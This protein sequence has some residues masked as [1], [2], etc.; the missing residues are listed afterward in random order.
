MLVATAFPLAP[1]A[2]A[3]RSSYLYARAKLTRS[4]Q[5][6]STLPSILR[7]LRSRATSLVK[8]PYKHGSIN[9]NRGAYDSSCLALSSSTR[10]IKAQLASP[11]A[12][13]AAYKASS[14]SSALIPNRFSTAMRNVCQLTMRVLRTTF[15]ATS[16]RTM[17]PR[18]KQPS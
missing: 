2:A 15:Q 10:Q 18:L 13:L 5:L 7:C 9:W 4:Y 6:R 11:G 12:G 1:N 17:G 16:P 14:K 8:S 3:D